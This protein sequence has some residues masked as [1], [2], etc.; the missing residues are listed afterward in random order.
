MAICGS[1]AQWHL[2]SWHMLVA[3]CWV[4]LRTSSSVCTRGLRI[5]EAD[6]EAVT[7]RAKPSVGLSWVEAESERKCRR[8]SVTLAIV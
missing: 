2:S 1:L 8:A 3:A 6:E 5:D 4:V 7:G